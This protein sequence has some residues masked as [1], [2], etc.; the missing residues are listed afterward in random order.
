MFT[1]HTRKEQ[2]KSQQ[3]DIEDDID[4]NSKY[5]RVL[6]GGSFF[7]PSVERAFC[8]PYSLRRRS[9]TSSTVSVRRGLYRLAPLL[10]YHLPPKG[11]KN[12]AGLCPPGCV[13]CMAPHCPGRHRDAQAVRHCDKF[14]K[15]QAPRLAFHAPNAIRPLPDAPES[16]L[17]GFETPGRGSMPL[18]AVEGP[19]VKYI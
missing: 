19:G 7:Y 11:A 17:A 18:V 9:G 1:R 8:L 14:T 16:L 13:P 6:R 5:S 10:L 4:I 12:E 2:M 3:E 15:R